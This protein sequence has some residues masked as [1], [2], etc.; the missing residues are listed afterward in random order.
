MAF[1]IRKAHK[2]PVPKPCI[3]R[4]NCKMVTVLNPRYMT[5]ISWRVNLVNRHRSSK[6]TGIGLGVRIF[7]SSSNR[8]T[9][10]SI[11]LSGGVAIAITLFLFSCLFSLLKRGL[12]LCCISSRNGYGISFALIC[13]FTLFLHF[14]SINLLCT[15]TGRAHAI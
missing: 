12:R 14:V 8:T 5:R 6:A 10:S 13:D 7:G 4:T 3:A 15:S 2:A 9:S 11:G 1:Y